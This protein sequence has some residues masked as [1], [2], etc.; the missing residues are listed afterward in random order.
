MKISRIVTTLGLAVSAMLPAAGTLSAADRVDFYRDR[1]ELRRD[2]RDLSYD[3]R[4]VQQLRA[5]IARE[6]RQINQ[7]MRNHRWSDAERGR[8]NLARLNLD[9]RRQLRILDQT[10]ADAR[11]DQHGLYR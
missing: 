6:E 3:N 11:R 8:R 2:Y 4:K 5:Q 9:L 7:A 10:R 1:Q